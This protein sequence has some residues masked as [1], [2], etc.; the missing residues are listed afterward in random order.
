[1]KKQ[2]K[3]ICILS[4]DLVAGGAEKQALLLAKTLNGHHNI[5]VYVFK[6]IIHNRNLRYIEE[7]NIPI[8]VLTGNFIVKLYVLF[9]ALKANNTDILIS[10]LFKGNV[11]CGVIGMLAGVKVRIGGIRNAFLKPV[12]ERFERIVHNHFNTYTIFNNLSGAELYS[13]RKFNKDKIIV[14]P[15]C[16]ISPELIIRDDDAIVEILTVGRFVPQKDYLTA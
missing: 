13:K 8:R 7:H 11:I 5:Y 15:N 3:N 9:K 6:N 2:E 4:K 16:I 1:M 14:I 10:Y 12:K